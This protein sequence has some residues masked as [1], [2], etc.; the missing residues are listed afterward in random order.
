MS[1]TSH[2][3]FIAVEVDDSVRSDV[4]LARKLE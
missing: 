1:P 2:G 4:E 3:T